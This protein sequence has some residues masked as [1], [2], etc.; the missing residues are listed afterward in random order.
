MESITVAFIQKKDHFYPA[1]V[2]EIKTGDVYY[3]VV[4]KIPS[5]H[6]RALADAS[7]D[8]ANNWSV[9]GELLPQLNK[10]DN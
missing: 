7:C 8:A 2:S 4:D 5:N 10:A 1:H 3:L 9:E 6:M